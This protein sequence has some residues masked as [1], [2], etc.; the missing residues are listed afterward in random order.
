M[1]NNDNKRSKALIVG[2]LIYAIGNFGTKILS[3]IIVPLYTYYIN[4]SD[5]GDYDLVLTTVSLLTPLLTLQITD[6]AY[7]WMMRKQEE[8][9]EYIMAVYKFMIVTVVISSVIIFVINVFIPI[10]YCYYFVALLLFGRVFGILQKLLRG[11]KN[12]KLFA[13]SGVVYTTIFLFLNLFQVVILHYGVVSLFQSSI[14][15][16]GIAT[17]LIFICEKRLRFFDLKLGKSGTVKEM[18]RFSTPLVPNQLSWWIINSSDRYIVRFFLGSVANG[19]YSISYKFPSLL[20]LIFNVFYDSWQDMALTDSDKDPGSYYSKIFEL[21]YKFAF[22][23]LIFLIPFTKIFVRVF[24]SVDYVTSANY[25]S[26]L[27]LGTVFQAFSS[28]FGVGYLK[29]NKTRQIAYTSLIGAICNAAINIML[30][31]FW[32]LYAASI[33]TFVGFLVMFII[34]AIQTKDV[35]KI[36]VNKLSFSMLFA[37]ALASSIIGTFSDMKLDIICAVVG[38]IFFI[39][40]NFGE[41]MNVLKLVKGRLHRNV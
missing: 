19:I 11:L 3:F 29:N 33:S 34:R 16:Y 8:S 6:A 1:E 27:Y 2:T 24:M 20:Q 5:L 40:Y 7:A 9:R 21:Y 18:L 25:I 13:I 14:I 39:V 23:F 17:V 38:L 41:I 15:A 10:L 22:S 31:K 26:F 30:I 12:Q 4:P 35:M 32:G 37:I 28:F 36:E